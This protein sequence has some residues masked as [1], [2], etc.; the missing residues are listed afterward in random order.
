MSQPQPSSTSSTNTESRSPFFSQRSARQL[1]LFAFGTAF[2]AA[3][4]VI[5]RRSLVR[6]YKATVPK[7]YQQSNRPNTDVNGA[8]EAFEALNIATIN[9]VSVGIMATGGLLWAFDISSLDD[10]R[11]KVRTKM[12]ATGS[13]EDK[14]AEE[15][16]EEWFATVLSRKEFKHLKG[17]ETEAKDDTSAANQEEKKP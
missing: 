8:M 4:T 9:V 1:G 11:R 10:M 16:I 5:T 3:S 13:L 7:F 15:E 6:R 2:F 12:G 17:K 14:D